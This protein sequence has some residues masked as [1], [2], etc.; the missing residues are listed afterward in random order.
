MSALS[1]TGHVALLAGCMTVANWI[2]GQPAELGTTSKAPQNHAA[3]IEEAAGGERT[4]ELVDSLTARLAG[5][6][7]RPGVRPAIIPSGAIV[8]KGGRPALVGLDEALSGRAG[9]LVVWVP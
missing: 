7:A 3:M 4:V 6:P 9:S 1:K 8:I 5:T 2:A